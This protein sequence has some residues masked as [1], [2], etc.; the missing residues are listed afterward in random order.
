MKCPLFLLSDLP[1]TDICIGKDCAWW[2]DFGNH[3]GICAIPS[4]ARN[5]WAANHKEEAK[6]DRKEKL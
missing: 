2:I 3:N 1:T 5:L 4:I 6:C